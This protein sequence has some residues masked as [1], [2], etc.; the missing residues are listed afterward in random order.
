MAPAVLAPVRAAA[1][2]A[3]ASR[4]GQRGQP[5]GRG[6]QVS[7]GANN[8]VVCC[9][10]RREFVRRLPTPLPGGARRARAERMLDDCRARQEAEHD[11]L[12]S[13]GVPR[14]PI[15]IR[16]ASRAVATVRIACHVPSCVD[17]VISA[18]AKNPASVA[19]RA[20]SLAQLQCRLL[21]FVVVVGGQRRR[22]SGRP[23]RSQRL[24]SRH[25]KSGSPPR[26]GKSDPATAMARRASSDRS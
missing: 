20:P 16:A 5:G 14:A 3:R 13:G 8:H 15:T 9:G 2:P 18:F 10:R 12:E 4:A 24:D 19:T 26:P 23:R 17:W 25:A 11:G 22:S 7:R 21:K 6:G 1:G